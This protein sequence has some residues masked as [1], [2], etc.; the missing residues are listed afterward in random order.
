MPAFHFNWKT[1]ILK[2]LPISFILVCNVFS[3]VVIRT[4][5]TNNPINIFMHLYFRRAHRRYYFLPDFTMN[6]FETIFWICAKSH[7]ILWYA[8]LAI[9]ALKI[10][11]LL[12]DI[13][14]VWKS[15]Q[16]LMTFSKIK[17]LCQIILDQFSSK[18]IK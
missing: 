8:F 7:P 1:I 13:R 2:S 5:Q 16:V 15:H 4:N 14:C 18:Y 11:L 3:K 10:L 12:K 9:I 6:W 17:P